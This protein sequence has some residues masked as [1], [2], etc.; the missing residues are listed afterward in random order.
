M[1]LIE[2]D[3]RKIPVAIRIARRTARIATQNIAL[4]LGIKLAVLVVG[5]AV[6]AFTGQ[7]IPMEI[8]MVADVGAAI[9][10]V[11]NALRASK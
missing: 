4:S 5:V 3:L 1:V 11:S 7:R 8:A 6:L 2:N 10:T 9:L